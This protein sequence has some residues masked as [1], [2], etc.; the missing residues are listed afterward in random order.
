MIRQEPSDEDLLAEYNAGQ[1]G[2]MDKILHRYQDRTRRYVIWKT[3]SSHAEAEDIAQDIFL[4]VFRSTVSFSGRSRFRTW[5]YSIAGHVC[6]K[7]MRSKSRRRRFIQERNSLD[8]S[9]SALAI[10]DGR[11][12]ALELIENDEQAQAVRD[13]VQELGS[14]HRIVL[15]LLDWEELSY[16]EISEVLGIPV[17]TVK[18]RVH[19]ARLKLAASL[20]FHR[21]R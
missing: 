18:S 17:G 15:L 2:A 11:P 14:Q 7:W 16:A 20:Q 5:F 12:C 19:H 4:Q 13:A 6:N 8:G 3:G 21:R 10:P 1:T 9:T